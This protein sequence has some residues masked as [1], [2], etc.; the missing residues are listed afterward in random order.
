MITL[1]NFIKLDGFETVDGA[2]MIIVKKIMG[3][4]IKEIGSKIDLKEV[5]ITLSNNGGYESTVK[6]INGKE[7]QHKGTDQFLFGAIDKAFKEVI[8]ELENENPI[9]K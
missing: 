5:L 7:Y 2:H 9:I 3:Q 4:H 8:K 1:N 6:V